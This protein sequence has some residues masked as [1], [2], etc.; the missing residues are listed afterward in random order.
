MSKRTTWL[1]GVTA[2]LGVLAPAAPARAQCCPGYNL[3]TACAGAK[4]TKS[5]WCI[6]G[7]APKGNTTAT[8][9]TA[10]CA[11]G[12]QVV[13]TLENVF[14]IPASGV[15]EF[16]VQTDGKGGSTGGAQTPTVCGTFGN[17]VTY[18]AFTGNGY[19]A[20]GFWGY[21]L[22]L[23]EAINQ[24]TGLASGGWPTDWWADHVSA[25]P[26]LM[27]FHIMNLIGTTNNDNN[28]LG[29]AAA[30]KKRF[31]PG[32]DSADARVVA[33]DNV[34]GVMPK[35]DGLAG[36]SHVFSM[37]KGDNMSWGN[38]GNN[39]NKELSEYVVAYMALA[40]GQNGNQVLQTVKG[41][42]ANMG[43]NIC[44]GS[45]DSNGDP[46]YMC[47]ESDI[48]A[49]ATAHCALAANGKPPADLSSYQ[50]GNYGGVKMGPCG[51]TCPAECGCDMSTMNC[52]APWIAGSTGSSS[53]SSGGASSGGS[54]GSSSSG[55]SGSTSSSGSAGTGSSGSSSG[56][57]AGVGGSS[58]GSSGAAAGG[59]SGF[60]GGSAG[61]SG[62]G[63]NN[64][65]G[66]EFGSG[67]A[68]SGGC[69]C[70]T[71]GGGAGDSQTPGILVTS[72]L[73]ALLFVRAAAGGRRRGRKD[74]NAR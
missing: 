55:T 73:V 19:G 44:N 68:S 60:G 57:D 1:V 3:A 16:D 8:L 7:D 6:A 30:Q 61:G 28:L 23:H 34:Y 67:P 18:D 32:G 2:L 36:F 39:P 42:S 26:N 12:E 21:L 25:F 5:R 65:G 43:G 29:A 51:S 49:I 53:S 9:P 13:Q 48:D 54:G 22:S 71:Q 56:S 4:L 14:N 46:T 20:T 69:S 38:L 37:V 35:M 15:F 66:N 59:S 45:Q 52:V 72:S 24:W 47:S 10:F 63:G 40:V 31:Y 62:S 74:A 70:K 17:A 41:P 58:T 11:Y 64:P 27:D 33:L 50:S